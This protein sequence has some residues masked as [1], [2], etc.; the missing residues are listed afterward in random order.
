M[1][2]E[3][4]YDR[5]MRLSSIDYGSFCELRKYLIDDFFTNRKGDLSELQSLQREIDFIR[6]NQCS[7]GKAMGEISEL[8]SLR[9]R[10]MIELSE[11]LISLHDPKGGAINK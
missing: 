2:N 7:P 9:V 4:D 1:R 3:I 5:L 11:K 8:I 10:E 6:A